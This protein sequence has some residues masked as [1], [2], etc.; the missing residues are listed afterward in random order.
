MSNLITL[1]TY[2]QA[3]AIMKSDLDE[4]LNIIIEGVSQLV[5]TYCGISFIDYVD[6]AKTEY[7]HV[8]MPPLEEIQLEEFPV[9]NVSSVQERTSPEEAY[10]P[11]TKD[12]DYIVDNA[13]DSIIRI[14]G[15][16][17]KGYNSVEVTYT[18]GYVDGSGNPLV[19]A[20]IKL[21]VIDLV[22]YYFKEEHKKHQSLGSTT[23]QN[24]TGTSLKNDSG[25]PDHIRRVLDMYRD[26]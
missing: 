24:V 15:Y 8:K 17:P 11:L 12:V 10:D 4:R 22:T 13:V 16:F 14:D 9:I 1:Q 18:A 7:H 26:I 19:P 6:T 25:F 2:K 3:K 20:D 5:K 21:A 23:K